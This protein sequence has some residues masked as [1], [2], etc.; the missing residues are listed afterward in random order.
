MSLTLSPPGLSGREL[1]Q[2]Y[3]SPMTQSIPPECYSQARISVSLN[4]FR[5]RRHGSV[6]FFS[7]RLS[8]LANVI[9]LSP[10]GEPFLKHRR[11]NR[12]Y[13]RAWTLTFVPYP[14]DFG[15]G[16]FFRE[17]RDAFSSERVTPQTSLAPTQHLP[18]PPEF[19]PPKQARAPP[20]R[21]SFRPKGCV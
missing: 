20:I 4:P 3:L 6:P 12:A 19:L 14:L 9:P 16:D 2:R 15:S 10:I 21:R 7:G 11:L 18:P 5:P 1:S 13:S 8:D 17:L